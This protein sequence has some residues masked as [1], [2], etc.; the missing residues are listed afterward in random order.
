MNKKMF[1]ASAFSDVAA[2]LPDFEPNLVGKKVTFIP[3]ASKAEFIGFLVGLEKRTFKKIGLIVDELDLA[4]SSTEEIRTKINNNDLIYISG[5]NTFYLLQ[6]LKRTGA[7]QIIIDAVNSGKLYI[8]ESA[9]SVIT[10]PTL[11]TSA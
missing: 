10:S 8:G 7:D 2:L 6:E 9:G 11:N 4:K 3:T 1:L 5:G